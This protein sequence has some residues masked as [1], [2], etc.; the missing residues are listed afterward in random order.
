M[1]NAKLQKNFLI[2]AIISRFLI[3]KLTFLE[4]FHIFVTTKISK[5]ENYKRTS[6]YSKIF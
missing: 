4:I 5:N 6:D 2:M 1:V 3:I